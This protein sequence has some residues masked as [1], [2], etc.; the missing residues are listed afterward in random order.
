MEQKIIFLDIDGTLTEPGK[1][2]VPKSALW[3]IAQARNQGHYVFLCTGQVCERLNIPLCRSIAIGDSISD[4]EMLKT[5]G[6]SICM[7]N[8]SEELK[9]VADDICP[10]VQEDGILHTFQSF[11]LA[12]NG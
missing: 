2:V 5:A 6:L 11:F 1:N 10:S 4:I 8:G 3:A 7:R 9:R 12:G